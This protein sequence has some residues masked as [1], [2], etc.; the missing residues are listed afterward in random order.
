MPAVADALMGMTTRFS[1]Y[2]RYFALALVLFAALTG[3]SKREPAQAT[4]SAASP[5]ADL[6][7]SSGKNPAVRARA[8]TVDTA[9]TVD[10]VDVR[11][12]TLRDATENAG[13]YVADATI[14]GEHDERT[15]RLELHVPASSLAPLL[16][17]VTALGDVTS[18]VERAEDVTEQHTDLK[19]RLKNART[20]EARIQELMAQKTSTLGEII[21]AEKELARV[22]EN[23]ERMDA[24][25]RALSGRVAMA[26]V[27]VSLQTKTVEAWRTPGTSI[28]RAAASGLRGAAAVFTFL[29]MAFVTVAPTLLPIVLLVLA[30]WSLVHMY[31]RRKRAALG[32]AHVEAEPR[33]A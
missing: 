6:I 26:T 9:L 19:A 24:E 11:T 15:G 20:Q 14:S 8:L 16:A 33:R 21:E 5:P 31:G 22:R 13:G 1:Q 29:A 3:C 18:Y 4:A 27:H 7:P 17:K 25:D 28:A 2:F 32:E 30:M 23:I 12:R 10:D